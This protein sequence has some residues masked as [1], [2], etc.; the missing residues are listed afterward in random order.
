VTTST[1][2]VAPA[3]RSDLLWYAVDYDGTLAKSTWHPGNPNAVPGEPIWENVDKYLAIRAA[4]RK[5]V[6][7]TARPSSDYELIEAWMNHWDLPFDQIVT[8]K[9][10]AARYIDDRAVNA[11]ADSWL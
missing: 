1:G 8:G 2:F 4:G 6:I 5:T 9:L 11:D 3:P 10:L 7:H